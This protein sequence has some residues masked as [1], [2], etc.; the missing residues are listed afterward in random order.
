MHSILKMTTWRDY[1]GDDDFWQLKY[2]LFNSGE[3]KLRCQKKLIDYLLL[4]NEHK[5]E[6]RKNQSVLLWFDIWLLKMS[7]KEISMNIW[8]T[9]CSINMYTYVLNNFSPEKK[10]L[11]IWSKML[12][13]SSYFR[14]S[15]TYTSLSVKALE[16]S[17]SINKYIQRQNLQNASFDNNITLICNIPINVSSPYNL[18]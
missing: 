4:T 6:R 11:L 2:S 17:K 8:S 15:L 1:D 18:K 12:I 5:S 9:Y 10:S 13:L 7:Y 16:Q 3:A 14:I